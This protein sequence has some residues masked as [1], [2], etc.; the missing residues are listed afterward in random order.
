MKYV[1][2]RLSSVFSVLAIVTA[3][4][5]S[6]AWAASATIEQA[7]NECI[8][9]EQADGYLGVVS[10]ASASAGLL[11]EVQLGSSFGKK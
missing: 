9:G 10:G 7:K 4:I 3:L 1:K 11:R 6:G 8:V 2:H 5:F